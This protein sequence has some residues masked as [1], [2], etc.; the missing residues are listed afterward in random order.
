MIWLTKLWVHLFAR[1]DPSAKCPA[2]GNFDGEIRWVPSFT[3]AA[4]GEATGAL[5]HR[6]KVCTAMWGETPLVAKRH[7]NVS[8]DPEAWNA[9]APERVEAKP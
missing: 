9:A 1:R 5:I 7:W 8:V 6:C 4:E 2:C 3:F